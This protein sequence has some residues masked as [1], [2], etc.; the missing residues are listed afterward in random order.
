MGIIDQSTLLHQ[1][2]R[3]EEVSSTT[4]LEAFRQLW[5]KPYGFPMNI[6]VDPGTCY[7]RHFK[8]YVERQGIFLEVIP[9]EAHWRIGLIER[10]NSVL[11]DI[12]ERIIDAEA[13]FNSQDF[14]AALDSAVHALNSMTYSHGR[15]PYMAVFGQ[16]CRVGGGILQDDRALISHPVQ[17]GNVRPEIFRAEAMKALAEINTSQ[18]LRRALLRKT[19]STNQHELLPGQ[20]YAYWRWQ[21]RKGRSTKKRGAWVVARFLSY[22]PDGKSAWLHSGTTTLQVTLEQIR[23]AFGY[24]QWQPSKEDVAALRDASANVRGDIW[25][26]HRTTAPDPTE[27]QYDYH[28]DQATTPA[29]TAEAQLVPLLGPP[30]SGTP[31]GTAAQTQT[32]PRASLPDASMQ[33]TT[34]ANVFVYSPT[35]QQMIQQDYHIDRFGLTRRARSR[36]PTNR[37]P[38][39]P[40]AR[41]IEPGTPNQRAAPPIAAAAIEA[42]ATQPEPLAPTETGDHQPPAHLEPTIPQPQAPISE[43]PSGSTSQQQ[44]APVSPGITD[45]QPIAEADTAARLLPAKRPAEALLLQSYG[46]IE[47]PH[48][49]WDGSADTPH[50][51]KH[52]TGFSTAAHPHLIAEGHAVLLADMTH[53]RSTER[54]GRRAIH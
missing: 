1:A 44:Q 35:H 6:R 42:T 32:T 5:F 51:N 28:F 22:D 11:R 4:V 25:E 48:H 24:K 40:R 33:Q 36:T 34:H 23:G 39:T 18:A 52:C 8:E 16:I 31:I 14:D 49:T 38:R 50:L 9:A 47:P 27:D 30:S 17:S 26:D 29:G 2:I 15:P 20:N 12:L 19:A 21:N 37:A 7:A 54:V 46:H 10:R 3:L 43:E 41:S 13:V 53:D 45:D